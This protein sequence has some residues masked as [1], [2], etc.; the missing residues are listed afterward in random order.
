M[1]AAA[2]AYDFEP[3]PEFELGTIPAGNLYTTAPDLARFAAWLMGSDSSAPS[4]VLPREALEKMFVP[5]LTSEATGY[6]L[7]FGVN[8]YR[9]HKTVQHMGAVYGFTTSMV[10]LPKERIG[11]IVLSNCD[12]AV[13][14][15]RRLAEAALDVLL[16]AVANEKT[17]SADGHDRIAN[18]G[19]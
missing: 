8:R 11:V 13:A 4:P 9:G 7:G 12:I 14:P 19:A 2:D 6:G 17:A 5:Q 3:A 18:R 15:V 1:P 10:V 16:D